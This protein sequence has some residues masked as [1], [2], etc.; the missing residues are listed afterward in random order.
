MRDSTDSMPHGACVGRPAGLLTA[1][2]PFP[3]TVPQFLGNYSYKILEVWDIDSSIIV[4][5]V[6]N[7]MN[8]MIFSFIEIRLCRNEPH[9]HLKT[10]DHA[11]IYLIILNSISFNSGS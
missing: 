6:F 1:K 2:T 3:Q 5:I 11:T 9:Y 7:K 10:Y 4:L 8:E